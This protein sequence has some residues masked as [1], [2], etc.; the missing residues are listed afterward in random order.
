MK[1]WICIFS[2]V[3]IGCAH[4]SK[5]AH[6]TKSINEKA[7]HLINETSPYLKQHAYNPVEWYP[8]GDEALAR[9]KK[10]DKLLLISIGYSACHWCHVMAHESFEDSTVAALM[11]KYFIN[12][13]IDREERPDI[14]QVYMDAVQLM[15]E[16]RGG[17]PLNA[18]AL[19]DGGPLFGGTYF[20][21][22]QWLNILKKMGELYPKDKVKAK[23]FAAKITAGIKSNNQLIQ[24]DDKVLIKE[25]YLNKT[26]ETWKNSFDSRN[27]G[28][29]R[30]PKFPMPNNF[31]FLLDYGIL[32]QEGELKSHV[33]LT[34][35][36]MAM[37]GIYDQ[38][39]GGFARYS[40]DKVWKV[41][42]FEKMLYDNAQK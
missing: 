9:A 36:K 4:P 23:E 20:P 8:W 17:W 22:D 25:D 41:P 6:E 12:I 28:V 7:N 10:E 13:K 14:D 26:V 31:E 2:I 21:K 38:V 18:I 5:E 1:I 33:E 42:H 35:D 39:G 11:N 24:N 27:G 15:N 19:P 29:K 3:L 40:V 32:A 34:L 16:G 37:G 30:A